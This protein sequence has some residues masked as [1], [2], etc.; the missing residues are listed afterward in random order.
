VGVVF[1]LITVL[2]VWGASAVLLHAMA[3]LSW[4]LSLGVAPLLFLVALVLRNAL[5]FRRR[6]PR[7]QRET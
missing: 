3:H 2:V 4:G 1:A 6:R 7:M 5:Q